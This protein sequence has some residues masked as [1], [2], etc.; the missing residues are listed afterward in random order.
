MKNGIC[1]KC[2]SNEVIAELPLQGSGREAPWVDLLEPEPPKLP[3]F[4]SPKSER[5]RFLAFVCGACGY[6]EFYA[7][8]YQGLNAI[9]SLGTGN[10]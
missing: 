2:G 7:D 5:S 6:T 1:L 4:W 3:F 10:K 9:R 8:N